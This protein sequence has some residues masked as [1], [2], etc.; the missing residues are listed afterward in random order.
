MNSWAAPEIVSAV[1][2]YLKQRRHLITTEAAKTLPLSRKDQCGRLSGCTFCG[3]KN[4]CFTIMFFISVGYCDL[5][6]DLRGSSG[7]NRVNTQSTSIQ[8][9][10]AIDMRIA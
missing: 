2:A 8:R 5:F 7:T 6:F 1:Q 9:R 10:R 4:T 3:C